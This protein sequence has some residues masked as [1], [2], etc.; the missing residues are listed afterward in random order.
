[1]KQSGPR[2]IAREFAL[3]ELVGLHFLHDLD[4]DPLPPVSNWWGKDDRLSVN[5]DAESFA[6]QMIAGVRK[7]TDRL[8]A[9]IQQHAKNWR[10]E[11]MTKV[12]RNLL[13]L[14][15]W[16]LLFNPETPTRVILNEALEL[17]KCYGDQDSYRF[18]NGILDPLAKSVRKN[19]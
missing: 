2:H 15:V 3:R 14:S 11:R 1:M 16:E 19:Q 10:L 4:I 5:R 12:D 17:A 18:V 6:R 8:D 13:R 9:M 7:Q